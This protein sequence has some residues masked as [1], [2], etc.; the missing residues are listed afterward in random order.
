MDGIVNLVLEESKLNNLKLLKC[1]YLMLNIFN[2]IWIKVIKIWNIGLNKVKNGSKLIK[3]KS[4][5]FG[6]LKE[7]TK[8][9]KKTITL[10]H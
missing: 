3:F 9:I 5:Y 6:L 10:K 7:E 8:R 2:F 1:W 4:L